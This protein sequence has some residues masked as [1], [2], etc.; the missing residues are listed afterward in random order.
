MISLGFALL[1]YDR[2]KFFALVLAVALASFLTQ[3]QASILAA[4]LGMAGSQIRDVTAADF[5]VMDPDT[6]CFD[7]S[8]PLKD[9]V[10]QTVQGVSG[11]DWAAPLLKVDLN[12]RTES[13]KLSIITLLGVS[14]THRIG[15][16]KMQHGEVKS[17]YQ[18]DTVVVDPG[19]WYL[20]FPGQ[21]FTP[22]KSIQ[23]S[24]RWLRIEG[25]SDASPPFTGF[26]I[27]HTSRTT[28]LAVNREDTRSATFVVGRFKAEASPTTVIAEIENRTQAKAM[29]RD[30]FSQGSSDFYASQGVPNLFYITIAIGFIVGAAF[31]AQ[32]F[33]M[34][35]KEN[36]RGLTVLKVLGV[37][38]GQL[39]AMMAMQALFIAFLGVAIGTALA[40][41]M[42]EVSK[43]MPFLRGLYIPWSVSLSCSGV[44]GAITLISAFIAFR[45]ISQIPPADVFRA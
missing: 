21:P 43:S 30:A 3:N 41:A 45:R 32:T 6:E 18:Q 4:F 19:G 24:D 5:W 25:L 28:A 22:G 26:P 39:A 16:P 17:I 33:L 11:V 12:A 23:V 1:R 36:A 40:S 13:G 10:L 14:E 15:E 9:G 27:V 8:K 29:R 42:T 35:V 7:Q 37:T 31:T 38:I 44:I 34:Y 20:L 2:A